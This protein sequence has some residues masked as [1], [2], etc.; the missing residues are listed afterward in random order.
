MRHYK[1]RA[2]VLKQKNFGEADRYITFFTEGFGIINIIAKGV[3]KIKSRRGGKL[4]ILN[5]VDITWY[6]S[7]S[8]NKL[9]TEVETVESFMQ[10]KTAINHSQLALEIAVMI[11]NYVPA[12]DAQLTVFTKFKAFI[13]SINHQVEISP[14]YKPAFL[15][16][17]L[18]LLGEIPIMSHCVHCHQKHTI[19]NYVSFDIEHKAFVCQSCSQQESIKQYLS[20]SVNFE[21]L[22]LIAFLQ[23]SRVEDISKIQVEK[24][25]INDI[26]TVLSHIESSFS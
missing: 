26:D 6:E 20:Q 8:G 11:S 1:S 15:L 9:L 18:S 13:E 14:L 12:E 17:L 4:D 22:K 25:H 5:Y 10:I 19:G 7:S 21:T 16:Q 2:F 3:R 24:D 23:K